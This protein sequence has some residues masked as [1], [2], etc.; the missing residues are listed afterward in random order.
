[1]TGPGGLHPEVETFRNEVDES[2]DRTGRRRLPGGFE[3]MSAVGSQ[4][5]GRD[6]GPC[7]T[8]LLGV[9]HGSV[10]R[11][12]TSALFRRCSSPRWTRPCRSV[13]ADAP[14]WKQIQA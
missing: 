5:L 7:L 14:R 11:A 6:I 4:L 3:R 9:L 13:G 12:V 10:N 8:A 2:F 1:M